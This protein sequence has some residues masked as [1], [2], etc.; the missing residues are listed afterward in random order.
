MRTGTTRTCHRPVLLSVALFAVFALVTLAGCDDNSPVAAPTSTVPEPQPSSGSA[1]DAAEVAIPEYET[2]LDL[3]DKEK[4]AVDG[5]LVAFEGFIQSINSAYSGDTSAR[6]DFPQFA[7]GDA[8]KSIEGEAGAIA[9]HEADFKGEIAPL[10]VDILDLENNEN[11]SGPS[12]VLV[13]FCV[14]TTKWSMTQAGESSTPNPDGKVT[15]QH[16][17]R[18]MDDGW[19]VDQQ[20][21]WERSC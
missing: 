6:E 13:N 2:D 3:T 20:N 17:I 11:G 21:L 7:S 4:E 1:D 18:R 8:L 15:M 12:T 19:K 14:D 16:T 9:N 10:K 5:A